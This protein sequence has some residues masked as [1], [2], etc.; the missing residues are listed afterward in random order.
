MALPAI[1]TSDYIGLIKV[2][3]DTFLS[4]DFQA[5]IDEI[6]PE[7]V[8]EILSNAAYLEMRDTAPLPDKWA[9]AMNGNVYTDEDGVTRINSGLTNIIKY[10]LYWNWTIEQSIVATNTGNVQNF[11]ENSTPASFGNNGA[12]AAKR[13]NK[14][15]GWLHDE[16]YPF[17][18]EFAKL[19]STVL[20]FADLGGGV[21]R[22]I[23]TTILYMIVGDI[24]T[25]DG[26]EYSV[27]AVADPYFEISTFTVTSFENVSW[28]PFKD[29]NLP[30]KERVFA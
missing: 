5:W 29:L 19:E 23:P 24:V 30:I 10:W 18:C 1:S 22:I 9:D 13:Y 15:V 7:L 8:R 4:V 14:A 28:E 12:I 17:L 6:Y 27:T 25:I 3:A 20:A 21:I 26:L 16:L 11:N 2:S